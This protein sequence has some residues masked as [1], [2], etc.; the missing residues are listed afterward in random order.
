MMNAVSTTTQ[1][2]RLDPPDMTPSLVMRLR[3]GDAEAGRLLDNLYRD[4]VYRFCWAYLENVADTEDAV[5]EV[6][7]RVLRTKQV[8]DNFRAW[9]YGIARNCCHN[10]LR[11]R[12]RRRA[13]GALPSD[14]QLGDR[15][16]GNLTRLVKRE[17]HA[18]VMQILASLP[19]SQREILRLRYSVGLS[20]AEIA[21]LLELTESVVKS[22]LFEGMKKLRSGVVDDR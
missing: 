21:E 12:A 13:E 14:S 16:S 3:A 7:C 6:F 2:T 17:A 4:T 22:R 9:V 20:R 15:L 11:Q 8:P 19:T 5:Q 1:E 10:A 18:R